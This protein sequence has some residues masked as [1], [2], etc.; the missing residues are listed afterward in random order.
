MSLKNNVLA[1]IVNY[2]GAA[3]TIECVDSLINSTFVPDIVIID[4]GSK[5]EDFLALGKINHAKIIECN[6]NLGFA[7]ANNIGIEYAINHDYPFVLLINNDTVCDSCMIERLVSNYSE[8]EVLVPYIYY[9]SEKDALWYGGGTVDRIKGNSKHIYEKNDS[10][11]YC[12]YATGCCML[13]SRNI[14]FKVGILPEDYFMYYEDMDYSLCLQKNGVKIKC[15]VDATLYHKVGKSSGGN[16]SVFSTYYL[17]RNRLNCVRKYKEEFR[18]TAYPFSLISRYLRIVVSL[19]KGR[20]D[21]A[22]AFYYGIRDHKKGING[23]R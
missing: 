2:N 8:N 17:T 19:I 16:Q 14:L 9:Y 23:R 3:D 12:D 5:E 15:I 13:L 1:I 21:I 22:K 10:N 20:V 18:V 7:K 4:N 6:D 11:F